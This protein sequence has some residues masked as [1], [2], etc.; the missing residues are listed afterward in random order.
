[1]LYNP[2]NDRKAHIND[3]EIALP[4]TFVAFT[5]R[6]VDFDDTRKA[7]MEKGE[8]SRLL[9]LSSSSSDQP[10]TCPLTLSHRLQALET[11]SNPRSNLVVDGFVTAE[12]RRRIRLSSTG[13]TSL[14]R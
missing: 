6:I 1:M 9:W 11:V 8:Q 13:L 14:A 2:H 7:L 3:A 10:R 12:E 5:Y 4:E